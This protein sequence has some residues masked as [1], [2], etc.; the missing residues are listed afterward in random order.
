MMYETDHS[1]CDANGPGEERLVVILVITR[2]STDSSAVDLK[3]EQFLV[4]CG[5]WPMEL[6]EPSEWHSVV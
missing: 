2:I 5:Q 4:T 1:A 6:R 3:F